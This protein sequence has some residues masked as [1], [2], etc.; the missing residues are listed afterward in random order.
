MATAQESAK[1]EAKP[2]FLNGVDANYWLYLATEKYDYADWSD[3]AWK[4]G[5]QKWYDGSKEINLFDFLREQG[6]NAF[7]IRLWVNEDGPHGL[8][9]ASEI[10]HIAQKNGLKPHLVIFLSDRWS[11]FTKQPRPKIWRELDSET[12][13][14]TVQNYCADVVKHFQREGIDIDIYAIGNEI[15]LGICGAFPPSIQEV[16]DTERIEAWTESAEIIKSAITGIKSADPKGKIMLHIA[17]TW[18]Y[19]FALGFFGF[20]SQRGVDFDYIGL[21]Y[22]PSSPAMNEMRTIEAID[23]FVNGLYNQFKRPIIIAEY[24]FPH[25]ADF[26]H[27]LFKDWNQPVYGYEPT[28]EGQKLMLSTF[29][30][31]ARKYPYVYGTYYWSPEWYVP[32]DSTSETGWG[33]MS[34]FGPD[35]RVLPA[36]ESFLKNAP[37]RDIEEARK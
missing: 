4:D 27:A 35:G 8:K 5:R 2:M 7:R 18:V 28:P 37:G 34:L 33:P 6:V 32:G 12:L 21:S 11:D 30:D 1:K 3:V 31:W 25:T 9:Y 29:L 19:D 26:T 36:V 20:M 15:D 23:S 22:Y 16:S 10:G 14:Q 24:A 17:M 13:K